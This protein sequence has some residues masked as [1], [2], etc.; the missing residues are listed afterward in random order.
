MISN[1]TKVRFAAIPSLISLVVSSLS[2]SSAAPSASLDELLAKMNAASGAPYRLHI[3]SEGVDNGNRSLFVDEAGVLY[4]F[5]RCDRALCTGAYFDGRRPYDVNF[6]D[7][8]LPAR[9]S[10]P[11]QLTYRTIVSYA[12]TDPGFRKSG[13]RL[14]ER[15]E[16]GTGGRPYRRITVIPAGGIAL[17]A[18]VD[19]TTSLLAGVS[20]LDGG[21]RFSFRDQRRVGDVMLPFAIDYNDAPLERFE[22]RDIRDG[23]LVPPAGLV[24][25]FAD[26]STLVTMLRTERPIVACT[27][28]EFTVPCLLD[29]GN[30]GMAISLELAEALHLEP[31]QAST[32]VRGVG[33]YITGVAEVPPL[34][35]AGATFPGA[36]YTILHDIHG[37]GYDVVLGADAL[38]HARVTIDYPQKRLGIGPPDDVA[39]KHPLALAF[40]HLIPVVDVRLAEQDVRLMID[41]GDDSTINL[42]ADYYAAHQTLFKPTGKMRVGGA[43]GTVVQ[44]TGEIRSVGLAGFTLEHQ[45]IGAQPQPA[46]VGDGHLGSGLL[47]HFRV[48]LDYAHDR[49]ALEP[50][51]GDVT[52]RS[53]GAKI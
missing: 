6:N 24:P 42:A 1:V 5:R 3:R 26:G 18:L 45:K 12:F 46:R 19:E 47:A 30:T 36:L 2:A 38:A 48:V 17:D 21:T 43:G 28:G 27:I 32:E 8:A 49:I 20:S 34:S 25:R 14:A 33:S 31:L 52:V 23:P 29:T 10:D 41:T 35:V 50:R 16:L 37:Y 51:A 13:G 22:R 9:R 7:T 4:E 39:D 44:V 40:E 11:M 15:E 53:D